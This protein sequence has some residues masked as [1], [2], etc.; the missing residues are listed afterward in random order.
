MPKILIA[1]DD[2]FLLSM[3]DAK[4]TQ[5]GVE[6]IR[7]ETGSNVLTRAVSEKPNLIILDIVM[8]VRDGFE[9]L[10]ELKKEEKTKEIPI[11]VVTAM[12]IDWESHKYKDL[13]IADVIIKMDSDFSAMQKILSKYIPELRQ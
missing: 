7:E 2:K 12:D 9:V 5:L 1:E 3:Y 13:E 10:K 8:P 4:L 6:V 11:V